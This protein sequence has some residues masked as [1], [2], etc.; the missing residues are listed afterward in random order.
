M[1]RL[2]A[3]F[4]VLLLILGLA[5]PSARRGWEAVLLL[6]DLAGH[7]LVTPATT[8]QEIAYTVD[9]RSHRGDLYGSGNSA[10]LI[11]VPGAAAAGKDDPRLV[12]LA[13]G[14][15]RAGWRVLVPDIPGARALKISTADALDIAD[16]VRHVTVQGG[17][18]AVAAVS[19]AAVPAILAA[20][21]PGVADQVAVIAA[22]GSPFDAVRVVTFFTTGFWRAAPDQSWRRLEPNAYGKWV[23]VLSN[24]DRLDDSG[25]R[26]LLA[27]IVR[28]KLSDPAAAIDDLVRRLGPQGRS[29]M[30]LLD[31]TAPERVP[32]LLTALPPDL[33]TEIARLDLARRDLS[34]L[35]A[36]LLVIHGTDD[37]I[38]PVGEGVALARA[39]PHSSLYVLNNLAHAD[40]KPGGLG[41]AVTPW[42]AVHRLLE[43]RDR[44][45]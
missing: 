5:A 27:A 13:H 16:A 40:L 10:S 39:V 18:T 6:A 45:G 8:R 11:L 42:Q 20:L 17:R 3:A 2:A 33:A 25:D 1:K 28:R 38:V 9:G 7:P 12:G 44:I 24:A 41:D 14:L 19:Y 15:A 26:T 31:N 32:E 35:R 36:E 22:I 30:A 37:R 23:F 34:E 4:L 21:E 43:W 29:V